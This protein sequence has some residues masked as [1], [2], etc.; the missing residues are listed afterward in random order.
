MATVARLHVDAELFPGAE[1]PL[2]AGQAHHL[3]HVLRLQAGAELRIFNG[4]SPEFSAHLAIPGKGRAAAVVGPSLR[5]FV[6]APDLWLAFSP[7]RQARMDM[8]V[9][10]ATEL[11]AAALLPVLTRR[12]QVRQVNLPKIA[13][14]AREAAEQSER[15]DLPRIMPPQDLSA[16]LAGWPAGRPLFACLERSDAPS[17]VAAIG[18]G[19][20]VAGL[21]VGP[22]GGFAPEEQAA[23]LA[24]PAVRPVSLGPRILRAETAAIAG[25]SVLALRA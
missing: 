17:L 3:L 25:L 1:I 11:G 6:A 10:K 7:I 5:P 2:E 4:R 13:A 19:P 21:L 23:L 8:L 20:V 18:S 12:T 24:H 9:E 22:E 15:L 16:L 14:Q